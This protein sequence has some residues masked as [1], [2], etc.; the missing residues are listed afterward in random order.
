VAQRRLGKATPCVTQKIAYCIEFVDFEV[1]SRQLAC[2]RT[3]ENCR[4]RRE[5]AIEK[6]SNTSAKV[7]G[8]RALRSSGEFTFSEEFDPGNTP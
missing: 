1:M 6:V 2:A 8:C 3:A 7:S 4:I 5:Y